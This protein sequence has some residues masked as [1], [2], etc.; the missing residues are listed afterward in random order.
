[1]VKILLFLS[2]ETRRK[3]VL[4]TKQR[5]IYEDAVLGRDEIYSRRARNCVGPGRWWIIRELIGEKTYRPIFIPTNC[6]FFSPWISVTGIPR[7]LARYLISSQARVFPRNHLRFSLS[8]SLSPWFISANA[9]DWINKN[10]SW[11]RAS[12]ETARDNY[13]IERDF[14]F[15]VFFSKVYIWEGILFISIERIIL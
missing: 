3:I 11:T 10:D 7:P 9:R 4:K 13:Q 15:S 2:Q 12:N 6:S 5:R 8:L 14:N 1:M